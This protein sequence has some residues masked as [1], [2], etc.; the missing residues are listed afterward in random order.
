VGSPLA[1]ALV[2]RGVARFWLGRDGWRQDLDDAVAMARS[3]DL[4]TYALVI[5]WKHGFAIPNGVLVADDAAVAELDHA[6]QVAEQ[7]GDD[8]VV[9]VAKF[10][11]SV[12][13]LYREA[14][15]DR[16]RGLELMAQVRDM[17]LQG[18]FYR[19]D[20]PGMVALAALE[21]ARRGDRDGAIPVIRNALNY[22]LEAGQFAGGPV[23]T[24]LLVE[25]LLDRG[26][27][28][29]VAETESAIDRAARL[30]ADEGLVLRDI[31]LLRMRALLA[32]ARGD[33]VAYRDL[34]TRYREMA[35]SLGF[36]GHIAMA[37]AMM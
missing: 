36:E 35:T 26:T 4:A 29:D 14:E 9:G 15:A 13:L 34:V 21:M 20:L 33:D 17:C 18:R 16:D 8:T 32:R 37:E 7:S 30:P 19:N 23:G 1:V 28:D 24:A 3:I 11:L 2:W 5:L 25:T 12:A 10:T 31:W 27:E 6:L 22:F